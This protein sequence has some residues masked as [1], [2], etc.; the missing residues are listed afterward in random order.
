MFS[1]MRGLSDALGQCKWLLFSRSQR[2]KS[3]LSHLDRASRGPYGSIKLLC[4]GNWYGALPALGALFMVVTVAVNPFMQQLIRYQLRDVEQGAALIPVA[5]DHGRSSGNALI[6]VAASIGFLSSLYFRFN[7]TASCSSG[8]CTWP[9]YQTLGVCSSCADL[10]ERI[11]RTTSS[12]PATYHSQYPAPYRYYLPTG[13]E[14]SLDEDPR[15]QPYRCSMNIST[16]EHMYNQS[17]GHPRDGTHMGV[18]PQDLSVS[19]FDRGGSIIDLFVLRL[20]NAII[21]SENAPLA[22]ECL[23]QYC[24]KT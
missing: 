24:V 8:N 5:Y 15:S 22:Q 3:H 18:A 19:Y 14:L 12:D 1:L 11:K 10:T 16:T 9:P 21:S 4:T 17:Y 20:R 7:V 2:P 6:E 23:L 13:F